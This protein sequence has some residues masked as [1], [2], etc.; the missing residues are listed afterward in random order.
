MHKNKPNALIG[1]SEKGTILAR[2]DE[3]D[4]DG[5]V[6]MT[7]TDGDGT[8]HTMR[9]SGRTGR[10]QTSGDGRVVQTDGDQVINEND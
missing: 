9:G 2:R 8:T 10:T 4:D 3:K 7:A 5:Q 6:E 1:S